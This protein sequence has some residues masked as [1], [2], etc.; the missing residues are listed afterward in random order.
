M[1]NPSTPCGQAIPDTSLRR[2]SSTLLDTARRAVRLGLYL[3]VPHLLAREERLRV[4]RFA[5]TTLSPERLSGLSS[6]AV[7]EGVG[8]VVAHLKK[9]TRSNGVIWLMFGIFRA[10]LYSL[11]LI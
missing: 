7:G 2:P 6:R 5:T 9:E 1:P 4:E 10:T 8:N 11:D 3:E